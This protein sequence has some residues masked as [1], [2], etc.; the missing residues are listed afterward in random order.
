MVYIKYTIFYF[1]TNFSKNTVDNE[2]QQ[3][4][5]VVYDESIDVTTT[6]GNAPPIVTVMPKSD[7]LPAEFVPVN[8]L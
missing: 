3:E 2:E 5:Q 1:F 8:I 7:G 6:V 4:G